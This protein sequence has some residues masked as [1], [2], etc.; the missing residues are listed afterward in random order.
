MNAGGLTVQA[1]G[2]SGEGGVHSGASMTLPGS[3]LSSGGAWL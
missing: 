2:R 1:N 3:G